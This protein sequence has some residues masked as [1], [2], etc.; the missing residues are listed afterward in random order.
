MSAKFGYCDQSFNTKYAPLGVLLAL[1]K[2]ENVIHS[3]EKINSSMKTVKFSAIDKLEQV[4][5]SIL[6]GCE[7]LIEVNSKLQGEQI[8]AQACGWKSFADQSTLSL[9]LDALSLM[10]IEQLRDAIVSI[11]QKIGG[12]AGHDWRGY[13]WLDYDLSS[14]ICSSRAELA[15]KGYFPEKKRSWSPISPDKCGQIPRNSMVTT[16][17]G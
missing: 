12:T 4:F 7:T 5:V 11:N 10:N 8:L 15:T 13:L 14:L 1:Y 16:L 3:L 6:A 2:Q 17:R 9:S